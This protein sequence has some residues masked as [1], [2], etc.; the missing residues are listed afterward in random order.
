MFCR[1]EG[2]YIEK[3]SQNETNPNSSEEDEKDDD[4]SPSVKFRRGLFSSFF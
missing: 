1:E 3:A 4:L 2:T